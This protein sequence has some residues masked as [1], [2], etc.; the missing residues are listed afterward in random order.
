[1]AWIDDEQNLRIKLNIYAF[2]QKLEYS[3]LR[4]HSC[5]LWKRTLQSVYENK[6]FLLNVTFSMKKREEKKASSG[7]ESDKLI[8]SYNAKPTIEQQF[9]SSSIVSRFISLIQV[10]S[11]QFNLFLQMGHIISSTFFLWNPVSDL[12]IPN[13]TWHLVLDTMEPLSTP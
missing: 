3:F 1:M 8:D 4:S 2:E 5:Q 11:A 12:R 7:H 10:N 13:K 9:E 6:P